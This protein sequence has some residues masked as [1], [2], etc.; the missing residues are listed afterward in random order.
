MKKISEFVLGR[1]VAGGTGCGAD[2]LAVL[3][4]L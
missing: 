1:L 4:V 3:L 2:Y